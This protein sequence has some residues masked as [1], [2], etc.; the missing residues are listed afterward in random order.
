MA[1]SLPV[2]FFF[3]LEAEVFLLDALFFPGI[4]LLQVEI[5]ATQNSYSS[6]LIFRMSYFGL[7]HLLVLMIVHKLTI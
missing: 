4:V 2:L 5:N 7:K 3:L 6:V 1:F